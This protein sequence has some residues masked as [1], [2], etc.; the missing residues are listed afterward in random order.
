MDCPRSSVQRPDYAFSH[1]LHVVYL[2]VQ[3]IGWTPLIEMKNI[4]KKDGIEARLVGKM[5]AY[6]PLC[7]VKDRSALGCANAI[8][9]PSLSSYSRSSF[10]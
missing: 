6:Q 5:E 1:L 10:L 7:S 9:N 2:F 8:R 3:L 4:A